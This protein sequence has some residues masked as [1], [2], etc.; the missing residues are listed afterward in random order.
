MSRRIDS[1]NIMLNPNC[2]K[3]PPCPGCYLL[4]RDQV[5]QSVSGY[6]IDTLQVL[7]WFFSIARTMS[8][9]P[10][11]NVMINILDTGTQRTVEYIHRQAQGL[12]LDINLTVNLEMF[13]QYMSHSSIQAKPAQY[14]LLIGWK[15]LY[16][17]IPEELGTP[18]C[19][20]TIDWEALS[21]LYG[22]L[23][24]IADSKAKPVSEMGLMI[25]RGIDNDFLVP[26]RM[27]PRP[28]SDVL[29]TRILAPLTEITGPARLYFNIWKSDNGFR[30][31][32]E[33]MAKYVNRVRDISAR[34]KSFS[35]SPH[36]IDQCISFPLADDIHM[37]CPADF[38][39][40]ISG[41]SCRCCPYSMYPSTRI[42][43]EEHLRDIIT[44]DII[45]EKPECDLLHLRDT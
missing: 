36:E 31:T 32:A 28:S 41:S 2:P 43:S 21:R 37:S 44:G 40:D 17:S 18:I 11:L 29:L 10:E 13:L 5:S 3:D 45:L 14:N 26:N 39:I 33:P 23:K 12:D 9:P 24:E 6:N 25:G 42:R 4:Y 7:K 27:Y 19:L 20:Q 22:I 38:Q 30:I 8:S 35:S 1:V 15:T 16:L 34:L